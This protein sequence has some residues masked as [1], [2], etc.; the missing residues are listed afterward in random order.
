MHPVFLSLHLSIRNTDTKVKDAHGS[1]SKMAGGFM[2]L[3]FQLPNTLNEWEKYIRKTGN[4]L[5]YCWWQQTVRPCNILFPVTKE[6]I[7]LVWS[8]QVIYRPCWICWEYRFSTFWGGLGRL[9]KKAKRSH[10]RLQALNPKQKYS[11]STST[12][13][14]KWKS[15][16]FSKCDSLV[17]WPVTCN[18]STQKLNSPNVKHPSRN[19]Q[20]HKSYHKITSPGKTTC[21]NWF[22][23]R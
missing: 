6:E 7:P 1:I 11:Q 10:Y 9:F 8:K 5:C 22:Q 14:L 4:H 23:D 12:S 16:D 19:S 21:W 2:K 17:K 13:S 3:L 15:L 20:Y 18:K